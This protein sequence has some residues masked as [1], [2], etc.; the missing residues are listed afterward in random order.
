MSS[1]ARHRAHRASQQI[2]LRERLIDQDAYSAAGKPGRLGGWRGKPFVPRQKGVDKGSVQPPQ[3]GQTGHGT[4]SHVDMAV[5][6]KG[7]VETLQSVCFQCHRSRRQGSP[8]STL[9]VL[10]V[11]NIRRAHRERG[12]RS[13]LNTAS[14][15]RIPNSLLRANPSDSMLRRQLQAVRERNPV[16]W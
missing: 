13:D 5:N 12:K 16:P 11:C 6:G 14:P 8:E 7:G 9:L 2:T 3:G 1:E 15:F 4:G 10:L